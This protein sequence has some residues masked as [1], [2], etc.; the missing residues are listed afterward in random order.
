MVAW[1][2]LCIFYA[3]GVELSFG[4]LIS[5]V[6]ES[7]VWEAHVSRSGLCKPL[8]A[9]PSLAGVSLPCHSSIGLAP[10]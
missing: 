9:L 5:E 6:G 1:S 3:D 7:A 2:A 8:S 10:R 4:D